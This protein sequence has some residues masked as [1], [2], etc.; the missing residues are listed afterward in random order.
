MS[1]TSLDAQHR[2]QKLD[3]GKIPVIEFDCTF[4][5]DIKQ[6]TPREKVV[7]MVATDS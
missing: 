1:A 2:R 3:E 5:T 6:D 7:I 4:G